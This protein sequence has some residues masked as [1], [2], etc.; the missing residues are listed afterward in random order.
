MSQESFKFSSESLIGR[1][2]LALRAGLTSNSELSERFG[3]LPSMRS[4]ECKGYVSGSVNGWRITD[5]GRAACPLRNPLAADIRKVAACAPVSR[6]GTPIGLLTK[7]AIQKPIRRSENPTHTGGIP[8]PHPNQPRTASAVDQLRR[9]LLDAPEGIAR[10]DL[11]K[12]TGLV[13][14][15]VDNA[16]VNLITSGEVERKGYGVIAA[17]AAGINTLAARTMSATPTTTDAALAAPPIGP[18]DLTH[19]ADASRR[20]WAAFLAPDEEVSSDSDAPEVAFMIHDDG[21]LT[22]AAGD[23]IIVIPPSATRRLGHFLGCLE[24]DA[25]PPRIASEVRHSQPTA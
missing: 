13:P 6:S 12:R 24:K 9:L 5:A 19:C 8:M 16:I 20:L 17:T 1:V 21:R 4:L 11:I 10:K 18:V 23:E 14:H 2:L 7:T 22:I 3:T 25:W 15:A